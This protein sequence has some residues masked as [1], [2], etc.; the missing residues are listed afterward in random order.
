MGNWFLLDQRKGRL[1]SLLY[2]IMPE[3]KGEST[4]LLFF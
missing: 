2:N 1:L 4:I 3:T